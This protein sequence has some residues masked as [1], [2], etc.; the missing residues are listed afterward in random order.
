MLQIIITVSKCHEKN[1][2]LLLKGR[3]FGILS[4]DTLMFMEIS[5]M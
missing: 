2:F 5:E 4:F 3:L 1:Q